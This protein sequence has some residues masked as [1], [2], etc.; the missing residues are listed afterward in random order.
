MNMKKNLAILLASLML[1]GFAGCMRYPN[2]NP[3]YSATPADTIEEAG[4]AYTTNDWN[5]NI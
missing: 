3:A 5:N 2:D 1:L 4:D